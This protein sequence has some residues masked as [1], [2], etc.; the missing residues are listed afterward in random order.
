MPA[1]QHFLE[2]QCI[3]IPAGGPYNKQDNSKGVMKMKVCTLLTKFSAPSV[4]VFPF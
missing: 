2:Q 3:A 1:G 4:S